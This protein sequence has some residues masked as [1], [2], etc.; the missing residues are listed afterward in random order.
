MEVKMEEAMVAESS[1]TMAR[2]D[3]VK[4]VEGRKGE[5]GGGER[6]AC[7]SAPKVR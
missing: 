2:G 1:I 6:R 4:V 3:G 5:R 7:M